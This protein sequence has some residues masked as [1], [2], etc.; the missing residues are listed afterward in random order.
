MDVSPDLLDAQTL[1]LRLLIYSD[2]YWSETSYGQASH[3]AGQQMFSVF[4][5]YIV[6]EYRSAD[7]GRMIRLWSV[8]SSNYG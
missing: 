6:S 8:T 5:G 7:I 4:A 3:I 1:R 2:R